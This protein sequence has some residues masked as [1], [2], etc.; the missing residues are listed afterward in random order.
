M[1]LKGDGSVDCREL[2]VLFLVVVSELAVP[3]LLLLV[4]S[5]EDGGVVRLAID[6]L[7]VTLEVVLDFPTNVIFIVLK[8]CF[9]LVQDVDGQLFALE[10]GVLEQ[11]LNLFRIIKVDCI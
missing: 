7:I 6:Q 4:R 9:F 3:I 1:R 5:K 2:S 10:D 11:E 8:V